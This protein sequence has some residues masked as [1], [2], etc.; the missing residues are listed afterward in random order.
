MNEA[1]ASR[2]PQADVRFSGGCGIGAELLKLPYQRRQIV[3]LRAVMGFSF[4]DVAEVMEM[5]ETAVRRHYVSSLLELRPK[6]AVLIIEDEAMIALDLQKIIKTLGLSVAGIAKNREEALRIVG[7][8]HPKLIVADY[9]LRDET[10]IDVVNAIREQIHADVIYIT[11]HPEA[12]TEQ[13]GAASEVVLA[14]PFNARA[15][16]AAVQS[17]LAA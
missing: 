10:G 14:K 13:L 9:R 5:T 11:A 17:K 16:V 2:A 6:P 3:A 1:S 12:V 15:L 8:S 4:V 7:L